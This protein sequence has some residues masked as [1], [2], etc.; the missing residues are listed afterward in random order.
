MHSPLVG[1]GLVGGSMGVSHLNLEE[2][3]LLLEKE[4]GTQINRCLYRL[5]ALCDSGQF[6]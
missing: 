4:E 2:M 1:M 3:L 6:T 5:K